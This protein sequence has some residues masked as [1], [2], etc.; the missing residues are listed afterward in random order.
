M[1]EVQCARVPKVFAGKLG[2][3]QKMQKD[4]PYRIVQMSSLLQCRPYFLLPLDCIAALMRCTARHAWAV[5]PCAS[6]V[7]C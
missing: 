2:W 7:Q 3:W 4:A 5:M 1:H 6:L